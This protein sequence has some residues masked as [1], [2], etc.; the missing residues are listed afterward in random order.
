MTARSYSCTV[1]KQEDTLSS[2]SPYSEAEEGR[3]GKE[4]KDDKIGHGYQEVFHTAPLMDLL[5]NF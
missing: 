3:D 4:E 5:Y 1:Y 2:S